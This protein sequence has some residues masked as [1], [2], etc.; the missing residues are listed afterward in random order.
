ML[1][2]V[3]IGSQITQLMIFFDLHWKLAQDMTAQLHSIIFASLERGKL[4]ETS[5]SF[6]FLKIHHLHIL[7]CKFPLIRTPIDISVADT[8]YDDT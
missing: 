8:D 4:S 5:D 3:D 2:L 7:I 1:L 6:C